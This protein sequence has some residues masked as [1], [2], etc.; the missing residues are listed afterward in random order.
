MAKITIKHLTPPAAP[1][2]FKKGDLVISK[3]DKDAS[4]IYLLQNKSMSGSGFRYLSILDNDICV[5]D[6]GL[7]DTDNYEL[8]KGSITL[9]NNKGTNY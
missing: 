9:E 6:S 4:C 8:F 3:F 5:H 1:Q 2:T 7:F